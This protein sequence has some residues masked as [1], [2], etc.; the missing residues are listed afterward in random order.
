MPNADIRRWAKDAGTRRRATASST[1]VERRRKK[2][3]IARLKLNPTVAKLVDRRINAHDENHAVGLHYRRNQWANIMTGAT[4][5]DRVVGILPNIPT[6]SSR[7]DREGAE[8]TLR[9]MVVKGMIT[10]PANDT[11][12]FGNADRADICLRLCCL[13]CKKYQNIA[14]IQSNWLAGDLLFQKMLKPAQIA[15]APTGTNLDMW[16]P[17]NRQ[18]FT[19]HYDKVFNF[20]R[21]VCLPAVQLPTPSDQGLAHMPAI[22]KPFRIRLKVKNKKL[23]F[24]ESTDQSPSNF[25]PFIVGWWSY[26]N[27]AAPSI[28]AVPF[29]EHFTQTYFKP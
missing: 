14:T 5:T 13:S 23:Y 27:G 25:A 15:N 16:K 29:V 21:G 26:T 24:N 1:V 8:V 28:S 7:A 6:A 3:S 11:P 22:N 9:S 18:V 19:V 20:K 12:Y 10:I 17:I 4:V 2:H